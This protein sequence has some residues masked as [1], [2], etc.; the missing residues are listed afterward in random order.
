MS[1]LHAGTH[2][3]PARCLSL[4]SDRN[5]PSQAPVGQRE[6]ES[7]SRILTTKSDDGYHASKVYGSLGE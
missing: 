4:K 3:T 2:I 6:T 1:S 7:I 5:G